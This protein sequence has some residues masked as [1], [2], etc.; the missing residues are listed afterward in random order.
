F[1]DSSLHIS[2]IHARIKISGRKYDFR[3]LFSARF[4]QPPSPFFRRMA[5]MIFQEMNSSDRQESL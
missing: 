4:L 1:S 2:A 3:R 5:T